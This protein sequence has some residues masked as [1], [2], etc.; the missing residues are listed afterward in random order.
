MSYGIRL[1]DKMKSDLEVLPLSVQTRIKDAIR[2]LAENPRP[3]GVRKLAD[4][5]NA[6]RV[7]VGNYRVG[8]RIHDR[9]LYVFVIAAGKRGDIYRVLKRRLR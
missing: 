7:R 8:Y 9:E 1:H 3:T 5:D 6:Y 4:A 2:S